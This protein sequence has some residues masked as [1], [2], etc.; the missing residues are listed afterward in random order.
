[1][2]LNALEVDADLGFGAIKISVVR[3][4]GSRRS[5]S[6]RSKPSR[7]LIEVPKDFPQ[8]SIGNDRGQRFALFRRSLCTGRELPGVSRRV[9]RLLMTQLF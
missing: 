4:F 5:C 9:S 6:R 3:P 7:F 1:V 8:L 2:A